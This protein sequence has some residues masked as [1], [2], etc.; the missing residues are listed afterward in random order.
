M[1]KASIKDVARLADV[2]IATVSQILNNKGDRFSEATREKVFAARDEVGYVPNISAR[3]LKKSHYMLIGVVVPTLALPY[4]G[5]F[6]Q[7][8]Q[9]LLP[10]NMSLSIMS[11]EQKQADA[12]VERMIEAGVSGVIVVSQLADPNRIADL[13]KQRGIA[14]VVTENHDDLELADVV[15]TKD[16]AGGRLAAEHLIAEGHKRVALLGNQVFTDNLFYR[17]GSFKATMEEAGVKVSEITTHNMSKQSGQAAAMAVSI[18]HATATFALNDELAIGVI[19]GLSKL[20]WHVPDDMSV[21]G[22]DDTDYAAFYQPSLT[23][24][25][26]PVDIVAKTALDVLMARIA[27]HRLDRQKIAV[28][29]SLVERDSTRPLQ[30]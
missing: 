27:D 6:V 1:K 13:L 3:S 22:Y 17:A 11:G 29:V 12:A 10:E 18:S 30:V 2:S 15:Y 5:A 7:H 28:D 26:Q 4:F 9:N 19:S 16:Q 20:G 14:M 23:T 8:L 25:H 21:I 24:I